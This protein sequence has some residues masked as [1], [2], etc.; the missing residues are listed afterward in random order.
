MN[1]ATNLREIAAGA[2]CAAF[3]L[4]FLTY[5]LLSLDIGT[6]MRMGP[7]YFPLTLG[8]ILIVIGAL[9]ALSSIRSIAPATTKT[10][11]RAIALLSL[12][13]VLWGITVTPLGFA[14]ATALAALVS[15]YSSRQ[16]NF[17]FALAVSTGLTVVCVLIFITGLGLP[18]Q[19]LGPWLGF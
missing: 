17:R 15:A 8:A 3:G 19:L 2:V 4:Y 10:P 7:G 9:I 13:P 14:P 5:T 6:P 16:M 18:F 12:T 1:T 11:W